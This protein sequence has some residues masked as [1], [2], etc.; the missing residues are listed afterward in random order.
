MKINLIQLFP[1]L[2]SLNIYE[3][4]YKFKMCSGSIKNIF[5]PR[6]WYFENGR[7]QRFPHDSTASTYLACFGLCFLSEWQ[8]LRVHHDH[9][10]EG[11]KQEWYLSLGNQQLTIEKSY[12]NGHHLAAFSH[13]NL[14]VGCSLWLSLDDHSQDWRWYFGMFQCPIFLYSIGQVRLCNH[15]CKIN[16]IK[17]SKN[18]L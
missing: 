8:S 12:H 13:T 3:W 18:T 4:G 5:T 15:S 1:R 17:I 9:L 11:P 10:E 7:W 6:A 14:Q 16:P 2:L